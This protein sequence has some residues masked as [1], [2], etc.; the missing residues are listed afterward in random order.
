M[1][2]LSLVIFFMLT[3]VLSGYAQK[4]KKAK[5]INVE[6]KAEVL[7]TDAY[8]I[9]DIKKRIVD[10]AKINALENAFGKVIVQGTNTYIENTSTGE[11]TQTNTSMNVIANSM[12]LG[13]FV[14]ERVTKLE[15]VV[16]DNPSNSTGMGQE[17]WLLCEVDGK[18]RE[19][20]GSSV[21]FEA[22]TLNCN[23]PENCQTEV[24]KNNERLYLDFKT[25]VDG[26]LSVFIKDFEEDVVY[27]VFPYSGMKGQ[28]ESAVPVN[29]DQEYV[30]FS[31][32]HHKQ[33]FPELSTR[34]MDPVA[35]QTNKEQ[36]FNRI[37]VVF[38]PVPYNKP[39]LT[40]HP[41]WGGIKT[42]DFDKFQEWLNKNKGKNPKFQTSNIDI[43]IKR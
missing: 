40:A 10:M 26:Y 18:A 30:L 31:E 3:L 39:I 41:E 35:V 33:Y 19:I 4:A 5:V 29:A 42:V 15:W 8:C 2:N 21:E 24:Y 43:V 11:R 9:G 7:L 13:E 34:V 1:K 28:Y 17:L 36:L 23:N 20:T 22:Y 37:F 25:P 14:E 12:V 32:A 16:R 6:G 27:R 38:S